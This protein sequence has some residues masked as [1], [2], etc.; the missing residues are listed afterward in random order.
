MSFFNTPIFSVTLSFIS[1]VAETMYQLFPVSKTCEVSLP[2]NL[3]S[4]A[5]QSP[6]FPDLCYTDLLHGL[7]KALQDDANLLLVVHDGCHHDA[8]LLH[9]I[10]I[11]Q[12]LQDDADLSFF[13]H[14]GCRHDADL[15]FRVVAHQALQD[16]ALLLRSPVIHQAL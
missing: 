12:A 11:R 15:L 14:D 6:F 5:S 3:L 8:N 9:G 7:V 2:P 4:K 16:E 1:S 10:V 13:V